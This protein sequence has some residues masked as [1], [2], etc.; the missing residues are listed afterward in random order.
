MHLSTY[1]R[2]ASILLIV[3]LT[4]CNSL[5]QSPS[6]NRENSRKTEPADPD[7]TALGRDQQDSD[8]QATASGSRNTPKQIA[9]ALQPGQYCYQFSNDIENIDIRIRLDSAD[10]VSGNQ[11]GVIHDEKAA[12]YTS[13]RSDLNG[14]IDGSNLNLDIATW[15]E[16]DQQNQ[17]ET[18]K[19]SPTELRTK[20]NKL[21][22]ADCEIVNKSFQSENGLEAKDLTE[23][24]NQVTTQAVFF[25]AGKS[26]T[27]VSHTVVRGDRDRYLITA[28]GGQQMDLSITSRENNAVFD[29]IAPSGIILGTEQS[30]QRLFLP[31]TGEYEI[32]VGGTRGNATY[33]LAI[34]IQ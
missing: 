1:Q 16:Y 20:A 25:E 19:V 15:I 24:A 31:D 23:I 18:W 29:V 3:A 9:A 4:S 32:I 17:Q 6:A 13:Y 30:K 21:T 2:F 22:K 11:V 5:T 10:R 33:D 8:Q 27:T 12:Y 34:A 28:Q 7:Q 26:S 14:T